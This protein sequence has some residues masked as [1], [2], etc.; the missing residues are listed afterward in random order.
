MYDQQYVKKRRRRKVAII[1]AGISTIV[2]TSFAIV[3]FLGRHSGYFTVSLDAGKVS[4]ALS[5]SSKFETPTSYLRVD[6]LPE[7][8]EYSF[9]SLPNSGVLDNEDTNYLYGATYKNDNTTIDTFNYFKYTFHVKNNGGEACK[10]SIKLNIIENSPGYDGRRLDDT[11]RVRVFD[12]SLA[13]GESTDVTFARRS[14]SYHLDDDGNEDFREAISVTKRDASPSDPFINYATNFENDERVFSRDVP[15]FNVGEI[16]RYT[17]VMWLEG[18]DPE[19]L[20]V[21]PPKGASL[22][23]GVQINAYEIEK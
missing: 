4:V 13:T 19:S 20:N 23:L 14:H 2:V 7:F 9:S 16:R 6:E 3:A 17:V 21:D 8:K 1:V 22:K 11:L 10:Y 12:T 15:L 18:W 5:Q